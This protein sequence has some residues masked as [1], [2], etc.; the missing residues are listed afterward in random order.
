MDL[1]VAAV[2]RTLPNVHDSIAR[3]TAMDDLQDIPLSRIKF[4][5]R[6]V[7]DTLRH[8]ILSG[9]IT[10]SVD[11]DHFFTEL[12]RYVREYH[13]PRFTPVINATGIVVHTNLGRSILPTAALAPLLHAGHSF[14]NLEFDLRSG[15]RGSRYGLVEEVLC[16]L[17]GAEAALVVNNNAAAVMIALETL[18]AGK[19]VIVSRGQLVEIG[20]SFRIPDIM[21][22]SGARMVEVGTTN[23]THL[24]DYAAAITGETSL[25]LR[26]HCSNYRIIGFTSEVPP[27]DLVRLAG[28]H[29]LAAME[30]L[31][32]GCFI[33]LSRFGLA[34]EPTVQDV[35]ASGMDIVTFSGD[36]LLGG[37]QAGIIVGKK[38]Y[39]DRIKSNPLNRAFRIDKLTLASLEAVLRLYL[40]ES[41]AVQEI[42][43]LAMIAAPAAVLQQ[44]AVTLCEHCRQALGS[45]GRFDVVQVHSQVGGGAMPGQDLPS[46][47]VSIRPLAM[48]LSRLEH[49]LRQAPVPVIGRVEDDRLLLDVRT[50]R[51]DELNLLCESLRS[52]L[53]VQSPH[54]P[55]STFP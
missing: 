46:W 14:S 48:K 39:I 52:A 47:A 11:T 20:G 10:S 41:Q 34:K 44:R 12:T 19:E 36:K 2:L 26:V 6:R 22:R 49:S 15:R 5:V 17:T 1:R 7:L 16:E 24:R 32:S 43:T 25:L 54:T 18:A 38:G 27:V 29:N 51:Q 9:E 3:L 55:S 30:D 8:R 4:C 50:V 40:D 33:D 23:R 45:S 21:A 31:G 28:Q 53:V 13:S 37:P 42:P 35:V